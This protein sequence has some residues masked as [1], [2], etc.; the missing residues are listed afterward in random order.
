MKKLI[1]IIILVW[2]ALAG[3]NAQSSLSVEVTGI[4]ETNGK[5]YVAIYN[6]EV[7]FLSDK[8]INGKIVPVVGKTINMTFDEL[9]NGEY[10]IVMYH[11][12]N[13]NGTLDLGEYGIP[14]EKYGFSNNIDPAIVKRP[15]VFTE[16]KFEVNGDTKTQIK[17]VSAHK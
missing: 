6:S 2:L 9:E 10:A 11:D 1:S 13:N 16:C 3:L 4:E 7:P 8:A 15:P 17:L 12:E 5:L 14:A